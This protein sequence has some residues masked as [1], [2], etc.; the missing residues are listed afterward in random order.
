MGDSNNK[1]VSKKRN[2]VSVM[3]T[4]GYQEA[5]P[6]KK[7]NN[8]TMLRGCDDQPTPQVATRNITLFTIEHPIQEDNDTKTS[9]QDDPI[10]QSIISSS[11]EGR[12]IN[13]ALKSRPRIIA[14][15]SI[16]TS[17]K[18]RS[19]PLEQRRK[20]QR[21]DDASAQSIFPHSF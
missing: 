9:R 15:E 4:L 17:T 7:N 21:P 1:T 18:K 3:T 8:A 14:G 19:N 10:A 5:L 13:R 11:W 20:D 12:M 16:T 2:N 6:V